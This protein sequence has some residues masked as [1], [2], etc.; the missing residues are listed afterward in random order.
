MLKD[1]TDRTLQHY[2]TCLISNVAKIGPQISSN[3]GYRSG[4]LKEHL[5]VVATWRGCYW[6][7]RWPVVPSIDWSRTWRHADTCHAA[8]WAHRGTLTTSSVHP[9][10]KHQ[11]CTCTW[12][13]YYTGHPKGIKQSENCIVN[14]HIERSFCGHSVISSEHLQSPAPLPHPTV[15]WHE[16]WWHGV[17]GLSWPLYSPSPRC[18]PLQGRES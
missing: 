16:W 18:K 15:Q 5:L 7:G 1:R 4:W 11:P 13:N 9:W 2:F 14:L 17:M 3:M 6:W 10:T 12:S 8:L